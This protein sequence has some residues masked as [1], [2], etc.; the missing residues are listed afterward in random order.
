MTQSSQTYLKGNNLITTGTD[1]FYGQQFYAN[2]DHS[3]LVTLANIPAQKRR[4]ALAIDTMVLLVILLTLEEFPDNNPPIINSNGGTKYAFSG[5]LTNIQL[6][7]SDQ[8]GDALTYI[9]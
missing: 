8:D 4:I 9:G 7:V 3:A 6:D 5:E 1:A 2:Y